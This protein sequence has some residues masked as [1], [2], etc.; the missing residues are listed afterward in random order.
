MVI[1]KVNN[2]T[3]DVFMAEEFWGDW[4][5]VRLGGAVGVYPVAG[6]RLNLKALTQVSEVINGV[7]K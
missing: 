2:N 4:T 6:R 5:R 3:F 7:N 1:R